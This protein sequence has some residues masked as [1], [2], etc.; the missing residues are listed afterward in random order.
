MGV[1]VLST[2]AKAAFAP[3]EWYTEGYEGTYLQAFVTFAPDGESGKWT[4][5]QSHLRFITD[6]VDGQRV[7]PTDEYY[8]N[9]FKVTPLGD[10]KTRIYDLET[11]LT[12]NLKRARQPFEFPKLPDCVTS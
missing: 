6:T 12:W 2:S 5:N 1:I 10:D 8:L 11:G 4:Y 3:G 7:D 9:T